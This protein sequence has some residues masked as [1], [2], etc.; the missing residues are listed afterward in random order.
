[1]PVVY[2]KIPLQD[3]GYDCGIIVLLFVESVLGNFNQF[4]HPDL[5][6]LGGH[7]FA[8][9]RCTKEGD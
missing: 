7:V 5:P 3:N 1:M 6:D 9:A 8:K 2:P 4:L